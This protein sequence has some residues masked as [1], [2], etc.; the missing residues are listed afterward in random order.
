MKKEGF[1]VT[2]GEITYCETSPGMHRGFC[3][4]CGSSL[5]GHGEEWDENYVTSASL[6]N[7][8]IAKP[9]T[10]VYLNHKQPWVR[11][12]EELKCYERFPE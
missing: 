9:T 7:P 10:N 3:N 6:D 1:K 12:D 8:H 5:E 11:I 4:R 2:K